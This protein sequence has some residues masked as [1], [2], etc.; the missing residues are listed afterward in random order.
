VFGEREERSAAE[1]RSR[2]RKV[3]G[4]R[5][6]RS[7]AEPRSRE[8]TASTVS[9]GAVLPAVTSAVLAR[10]LDELPARL[11]RKVDDMVARAALWPVEP[12]GEDVRVVVD[13]QTGVLLPATGVVGDGAAVRCSCLLAPNCLHRAAVLARCPVDD[14]AA[15]PAGT[16]TAAAAGTDTPAAAGTPGLA[17]PGEVAVPA[18]LSP[19]QRAAAADLARAGAAVLAAGLAGSGLVLRTALLRAGYEARAHGLHRPA[20]VA[21][22]VAALMR[23]SAEQQPHYRLA[24]LTDQLRELLGL[25]RLLAGP[26]RDPATVPALLGTARRPYDLR[27]SLRLYGLCTVP[28]APD[29]GYGGVATYLVDRDSRMWMVADLMPGGAGRA[30]AAGDATVALGETALTHRGLARAGLVVS[31]ATASATGQL[32]AGASVRAVGA[33]G[34][35]WHAEPLAAL[36]REPLAAQVR[37]AYAALALPVAERPAGADLMFLRV[38]VL[39]PHD[40]GLL[41]STPDGLRLTVAVAAEHESLPYRENLRLLAGAPGLPVLLVGVPDAGRPTRL[42]GYALAPDPDADPD[43]AGPTLVPPAAG[44]VDLG[45]DRLHASHLRRVGT[46]GRPGG[47]QTGGAPDAARDAALRLLRRHVERVV[48][49]GRAAQALARTEESQLRRARLD[50]GAEVLARLARTAG[51]YARDTFGRLAAD[52]G[53]AFTDAWLA[54]AL[55]EQAAARTLLEASWLPAAELAQAAGEPVPPPGPVAPAPVGGTATTTVNRTL[56]AG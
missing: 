48:A 38:R 54:A 11:R 17:D 6:E 13:E 12:A 32:G 14:E 34:A 18:G 43:G 46:P 29:S 4:E 49:G 19:V 31:G 37:R 16:V 30:A 53:V 50:T 5:E 25:C 35:A 45:Y 23:A 3:L 55:Y 33:A 26:D 21:R 44:H 52:D 42:L 51:A 40:D 39:G 15:P 10:A 36:W 9:G 20:A 41:A 28:V 24:D 2:E 56:N 47:T 27:G 1:P 7:A 22:Q 8:R